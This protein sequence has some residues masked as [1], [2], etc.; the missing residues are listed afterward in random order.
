MS[1]KT[2]EEYKEIVSYQLNFFHMI[3]KPRKYKLWETIIIN[4]GCI[5]FYTYLLYL[6]FTVL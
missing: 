3:Y 1:K 5:I 4:T 2:K 6:L